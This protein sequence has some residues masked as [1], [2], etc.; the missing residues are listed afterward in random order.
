MWA[1]PPALTTFCCHNSEQSLTN[2]QFD[3]CDSG[4]FVLPSTPVDLNATNG[5]TSSS[6]F[7]STPATST[8]SSPTISATNLAV[9]TTTSSPSPSGLS[10]GAKAGV[11]VGVAVAALLALGLGLGLVFRRRHRNKQQSGSAKD[12]GDGSTDTAARGERANW[13]N[14]PQY[15]DGPAPRYLH[16]MH[17]PPSVPLELSSDAQVYEV[18]SDAQRHEL[19]G[20]EDIAEK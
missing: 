5:Q 9:P 20:R 18:P 8:S 2:Q 15:M 16:E 19:P 13:A 4:A 11:G 7:S 17:T 6:A 12:Y 3:C 10:T 14:E 1:C